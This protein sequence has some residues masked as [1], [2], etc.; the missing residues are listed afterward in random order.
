MLVN[1][2]QL[3][4][5][6]QKLLAETEKAIDAALIEAA[7]HGKRDAARATK[8]KDRSGKLRAGTRSKIVKLKNGRRV[9]LL[10]RRKYAAAIDKGSKAH[11]IRAKKPGGFLRFM[12]S[13]GNLVF[14]RMVRHPGT[15]PTY[16]LRDARTAAF[17]KAGS[18]LRSRLRSVARRF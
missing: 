14:R 10:N 4:R 13:G 5:S 12:G 9:V 6:H 8:Y 11:I 2:S 15:K 16:F 3:K 17:D 1:L 18:L 7:K